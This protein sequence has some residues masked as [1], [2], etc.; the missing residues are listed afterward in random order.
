MIVDQAVDQ[1]A[2][3][4]VDLTKCL[5]TAR[6]TDYYLLS[7]LLTDAE[8]KIR[9]RVR[10]FASLAKMYTAQKARSVCLEARDILGGNGLLLEFHVARHMTDTE[11]VHT[12]EGTDSIQSLI[13]GRDV[14][15]ISAF[16]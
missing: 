8:R 16:A 3:L 1:A 11:V 14:T 9:D 7:E 15:G 12:D 6:G 5:T 10:A 4:T 2:D 13:V